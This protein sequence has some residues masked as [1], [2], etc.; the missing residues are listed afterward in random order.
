VASR[1]RLSQRVNWLFNFLTGIWREPTGETLLK[2]C[3]AVLTS[4]LRAPSEAY[5]LQKEHDID[6]TISGHFLSAEV[7][8]GQG[9]SR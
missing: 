6:I 7:S 9:M 5:E 2:S 3:H 1:D 4:I 8:L